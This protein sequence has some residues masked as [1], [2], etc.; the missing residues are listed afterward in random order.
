MIVSVNQIEA[1]IAKAA[2]G[3]GWPHGLAEE[4]GRAAAWLSTRGF[5]GV[6]TALAAIEPGP[7]EP[8]IDETT[9]AIVFGAAQAIHAAPSA[10]DLL[11]ADIGL[12]RV[13]L[14]EID[15][16]LLVIGFGGMAALAY[17]SCYRLTFAEGCRVIVDGSAVSIAGTLPPSGAEA[18]IEAEGAGE[19][20]TPAVLTDM[21]ID[22]S[23]WH[24]ALTMAAESYVASSLSSRKFGAGA[25]II[26]DD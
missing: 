11:A 6:R 15:Q 4:C 13:V 1:T 23:L 2:W 14:Q 8:L 7:A 25:G 16:P 10:Y 5:D 22:G 26:D 3:R 9:D 21:E 12:E 18:V 17:Q 19:E 20:G 24:D